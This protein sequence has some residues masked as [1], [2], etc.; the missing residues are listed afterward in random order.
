MMDC[1]L[2]LTI[3]RLDVRCNQIVPRRDEATDMC[4]EC[5][6]GRHMPTHAFKPLMGT[7]TALS[8]TSVSRMDHNAS[9]PHV[10][11]LRVS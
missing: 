4:P 11:E 8:V 10:G 9:F 7:N 6:V 2:L 1:V 5:S 3:T